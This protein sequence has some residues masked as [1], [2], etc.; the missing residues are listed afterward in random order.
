MS[1]EDR[2]QQGFFIKNVDSFFIYL[3]LKCGQV[4]N[5]LPVSWSTSPC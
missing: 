3:K 2:H 1:E 4:L 5:I